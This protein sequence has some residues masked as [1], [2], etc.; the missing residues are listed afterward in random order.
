MGI[1]SQMDN[2]IEFTLLKCAIQCWGPHHIVLAYLQVVHEC[3]LQINNSLKTMS[4][5]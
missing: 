5:A 1:S 2:E 3:C 4:F